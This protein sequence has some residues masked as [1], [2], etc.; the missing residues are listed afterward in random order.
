MCPNP[1]GYGAG[2]IL[3]D[4]GAD[5]PCSSFY[6]SI[7]VRAACWS[8]AL[9]HA[10]RTI[11]RLC[12]GIVG[13]P[14]AQGGSMVIARLYRVDA[15]SEVRPT[16]P[17]GESVPRF[18]PYKAFHVGRTTEPAGES[19]PRFLPYNAFADHL[20]I[21]FRLGHLLIM[22]A[23]SAVCGGGPARQVPPPRERHWPHPIRCWRGASL[24]LLGHWWVGC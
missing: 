2:H 18:L 23:I 24:M 4:N 15:S 5:R 19:V 13:G 20:L 22:S 16:G 7:L 1:P 12:R 11:P 6:W 3:H 14:S 10:R 17:A 9:V 8:A 21:A